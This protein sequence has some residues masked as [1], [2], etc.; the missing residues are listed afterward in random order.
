MPPYL[1]YWQTIIASLL[2]GEHNT[3]SGNMKAL[4]EAREVISLSGS[5][6]IF[7]QELNYFC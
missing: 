1:G 6:S 3:A 4:G 2:A 5:G 7:W